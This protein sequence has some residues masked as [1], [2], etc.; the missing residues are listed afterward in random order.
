MNKLFKGAALLCAM[1]TLATGAQAEGY[2]AGTYT[3]SSMGNN[4]D[5][6]V[7]VEFDADAIKSVE[8]TEHK[9]TSGISDKA[10]TDLPAAIVEHQALSV[11]TVS[12]AT[13]TSKAIL[14][15][16]EAALLKLAA[17]QKHST[18]RKSKRL[19]PLK[20]LRRTRTSSFLAAA[21]PA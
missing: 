18:P 10:I 13:N 16:V 20:R 3:A 19:S 14:S 8:V 7:S 17:T 6:T 12:G 9:E 15:A 11:D 1:A 4:G 21:V 2:K 5:V